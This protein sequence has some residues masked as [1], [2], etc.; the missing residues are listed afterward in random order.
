MVISVVMLRRMVPCSSGDV[1]LTEGTRGCAAAAGFG[2]G[3]QPR[4]GRPGAGGG[5]VFAGGAESGAGPSGCAVVNAD[6]SGA[7]AGAVQ[8]GAW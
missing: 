1:V 6:T 4:I 7:G 2:A 5:A 3:M 8:G